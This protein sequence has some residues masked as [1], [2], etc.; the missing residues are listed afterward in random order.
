MGVKFE[1]V[2]HPFLGKCFFD[3]LGKQMLGKACPSYGSSISFALSRSW[4]S[5]VF[6]FMI[7]VDFSIFP[8]AGNSFWV[9]LNVCVAGKSFLGL[10]S[11]CAARKTHFWCC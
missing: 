5:S 10:L 8:R 4:S 3:F 1:L 6:P 9:L 7:L 2:S 11:V